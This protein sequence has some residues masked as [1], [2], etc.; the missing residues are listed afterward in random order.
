[1]ETDLKI[2]GKEDRLHVAS[3]L[4]DNGYEVRQWKQ[5]KTPTG[6]SVDYYLHVSDCENNA[7]TSKIGKR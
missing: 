7:D 1:M 3:I 4:I 6:K 5:A 2:Y